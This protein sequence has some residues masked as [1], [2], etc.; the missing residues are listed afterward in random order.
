W[1]L[2]EWQLN[3]P[4]SVGEWISDGLLTGLYFRI[5]SY[6]LTKTTE[7][8]VSGV[9]YFDELR[10]VKKIVG[11]TGIED[12]EK[13]IPKDFVLY[14]NYPNPFNPVTIISYQLPVSSNVTLKVYDILGKE[15]AILVNEEKPM[16]SYE[17]TWNAS[18]AAGGL[19]SGVYFYRL[20]AGSFVQTRKM[21]LLK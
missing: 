5:D 13:L 9:L 3:D 12:S 6:Q 17:I 16:G 8:S 1:K 20:Q 15:V 14:Q 19:P 2:V 21:I 18:S 11:T 4:N 10:A 7:S